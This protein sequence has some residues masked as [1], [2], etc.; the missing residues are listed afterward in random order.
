MQKHELINLF[1]AWGLGCGAVRLKESRTVGDM[2]WWGSLEL[3]QLLVLTARIH[4][5]KS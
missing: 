1:I 2:I 3:F 4:V 5:G